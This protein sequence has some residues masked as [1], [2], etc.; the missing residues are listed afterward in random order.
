MF[1]FQN[2]ACLSIFI[3]TIS[4][5][6]NNPDNS[7]PSTTFSP[8]LS[9]TETSE[10]Q[11]QNQTAKSNLALS[12]D[13]IMTVNA[14]TGSTRNF[15]FDSDLA[16]T[17]NVVT[18]ILGQPKETSENAECP[19]GKLTTITWPNGFAINAAE[20]KFV[21]WSVRPQTESAK[22]TT[23]SNIGIGSTVKDLQAAYN[24]KV[25]DSSLGVEFNVGQ[26]SGLLSKNAPDGVITELWGGTN[27]I[28]R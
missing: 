22:L 17:K 23:M 20:N 19:A 16:I 14:Q 1:N 21:G 11:N 3:L 12:N 28:F 25:F 5:C 10:K 9:A 27:C 26:M 8:S 13:G 7:N 18:A 24:I 6:T 15:T 4:G 2:L